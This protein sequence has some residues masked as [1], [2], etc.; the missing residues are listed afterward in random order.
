MQAWLAKHPR[1]KLHFTPTSCSWLNLV[2][3]LFAEITRQR[4]R[5]GVFRSVD[6]LE[7]A[8]TEWLAHQNADPKPFEWTAKPGTLI[9]KHRRAK[10]ALESL[11]TGCK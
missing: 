2:G 5:R 8:I 3:R 6:E 10:K 11:E 1:F 9:G 7:V 4:I